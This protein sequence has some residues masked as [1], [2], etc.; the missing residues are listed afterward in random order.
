[1]I[2]NCTQFVFN[3]TD[4]KDEIVLEDKGQTSSDAIDIVFPCKS[5]T[6]KILAFASKDIRVSGAVYKP[7]LKFSNLIHISIKSQYLIEDM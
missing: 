5:G 6:I 2:K 3:L 1:M 7:Q 4:L